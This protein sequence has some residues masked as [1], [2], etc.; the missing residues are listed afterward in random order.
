[1]NVGKGSGEI[2][3]DRDEGG[4]RAFEGETEVSA[5]RGIAEGRGGGERG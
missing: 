1:M 4:K 3:W 5:V 2:C